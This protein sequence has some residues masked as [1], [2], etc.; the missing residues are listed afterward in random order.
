MIDIETVTTLIS[1]I[2]DDIR[3]VTD[4]LNHD[5]DQINKLDS[6]LKELVKK[7][8]NVK[9]SITVLSNQKK[10][11]N[12]KIDEINTY[13]TNL[14]VQFYENLYTLLYN[15]AVYD[16]KI[17]NRVQRNK[18]AQLSEYFGGFTNDENVPETGHFIKFKDNE[19][20]EYTYDHITSLLSFILKAFE[21][22]DTKITNLNTIKD[23]CIENR[24]NGF[25]LDNIDDILTEII[26]NI[27][28][29]K[30]DFEKE[31]NLII[32]NLA[33]N[34]AEN[35]TKLNEAVELINKDAVSLS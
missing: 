2:T 32:E 24:N 20:P 14:R 17:L 28:N 4:G 30:N 18:S 25:N 9:R 19:K 33:K 10:G 34:N 6:Y 27:I 31:F 13:K 7:N 11:L 16:Y 22:I 1:T 29:K 8:V 23:K 3:K 21:T 15:I 5:I 35:I 26:N 12:K